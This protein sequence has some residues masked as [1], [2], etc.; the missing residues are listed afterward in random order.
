ML[1]VRKNTFETNSS[2]THC[3]CFSKDR[4]IVLDETALHEAMIIEPLTYEEID[5]QMTF[6][7][8]RDKLRYFLT[9]YEQA[10][11]SGCKFMQILQKLCPN[12]VFKHT[13]STNK[14]VL[15]DAEWFF[16]YDE[17]ES[18]KLTEEALKEVLLVGTIYFGNRDNENYFDKIDS[19]THDDSMFSVSWSG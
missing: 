19:I 16:S 12:V 11:F 3:L 7:T 17:P 13:F 18:D 10:D 4:S 14:Y 15:E 8:V 2:S 5:E 1:T 6:T 9:V